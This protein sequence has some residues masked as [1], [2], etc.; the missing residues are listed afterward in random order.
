MT[1]ITDA[2]KLLNECQRTEGSIYDL[3]SFSGCKDDWDSIYSLI[4]RVQKM[5]DECN[6]MFLM[7]S[8]TEQCSKIITKRNH[9]RRMSMRLGAAVMYAKNHFKID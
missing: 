8:A 4:E 6:K 2:K 3:I 7:L 9:L 1:I 5:M